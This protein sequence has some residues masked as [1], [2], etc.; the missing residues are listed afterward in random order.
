MFVCIKG[1]DLNVQLF[2]IELSDHAGYFSSNKALLVPFV[3]SVHSN[4]NV[5]IAREH[6]Y[7]WFL[8]V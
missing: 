2:D 1:K 6:D 3:Y 4:R 8:H 5:V 7:Y